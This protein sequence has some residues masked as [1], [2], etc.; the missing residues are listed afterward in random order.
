M[1]KPTY[2]SAT[3]PGQPPSVNHTY[4]I[5]RKKAKDRNGQ[6]V[7]GL[8]G[9]PKTYTSLIK[10]AS[11]KDYQNGI[12]LILQAARPTGFQPTGLVYVAYE[13]FL[14]RDID[15]DNTNKAIHDVLSG[16]IGVNDRMFMPLAIHKETKVKNPYVRLTVYD[17]AAW[18]IGVAPR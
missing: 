17:G 9:E 8:D 2:W 13:F 11:V 16:V 6:P 4:I 14:D 12:R 7:L 5:A 18:K 10:K 1:E 15:V 3:L